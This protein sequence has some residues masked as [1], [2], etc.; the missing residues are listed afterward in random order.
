MKYEKPIC[1]F[2]VILL[3]VI[4]AFSLFG[5]DAAKKPQKTITVIFYPIGSTVPD[6][7]VALVNVH[8]D[9]L[10]VTK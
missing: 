4:I 1:Q 6:T 8:P 9:T 2:F 10:I 7:I 3:L 5:Q